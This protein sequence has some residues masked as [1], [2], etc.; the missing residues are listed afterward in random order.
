[1]NT[2]SQNN[3]VNG[4]LQVEEEY[5]VSADERHT[6]AKIKAELGT[7]ILAMRQKYVTVKA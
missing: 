1:M 7:R 4:S 3:V 5:T 2:C 6:W